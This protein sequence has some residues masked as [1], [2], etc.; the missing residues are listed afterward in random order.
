MKL[1]IPVQDLTKDKEE[2]RKRLK[3][4]KKKIFHFY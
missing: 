2:N 1:Q 3:E 4:I